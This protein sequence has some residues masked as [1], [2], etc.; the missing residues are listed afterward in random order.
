MKRPN[1][2]LINA[3]VLLTI[4]V[5]LAFSGI[6]KNAK[7]AFSLPSGSAGLSA[8]LLSTELGV[9]EVHG[10]LDSIG[11]DSY[12]VG[13]FTFRF[14][15]L[16]MVTGDLAV[17]DSVHIKALLLPDA[18][19]YALSIEE[20]ATPV[21]TSEFETYGLVDSME[22]DVWVISSGIVTLTG[23]TVIDAG[24]EVGDLVQVHGVIS[25]GLLVAG[26]ITLVDGDPV[27]SGT[28]VE[29]FGTIESITGSV[30][31][32][33]G[34]TVNTDAL[35]LIDPGLMVGDLVKVGAILNADGTYLA[36]AIQLAIMPAPED[37]TFTGAVESISDS[38]WLVGGMTF[39]VDAET[40]ITGDPLVGDMVLVTYVEQSDGSFLALEITKVEE[41]DDD[42][43]NGSRVFDFIGALESISDTEWVVGGL[44]FA[45]TSKT[46]LEGEMAVGDIV[47]VHAKRFSDGS[48]VAM[49]IHPA[50]ENA[51]DFTFVGEV[52][53]M[54][55]AAWVIDG[56]TLVIDSSTKINGH[57]SVGDLVKVHAKLNEDGTYTAVKI[58]PNGPR[59]EDDEDEDDQ[60]VVE[61]NGTVESVAEGSWVVGGMTFIVD[62]STEFE[63]D[64][65]LGDFVEVEY[66][67]Q[68]DG[69]LLA[70]KI[71]A[72]N[73]DGP[74][75][76]EEVIEFNGLVE[77]VAEDLWVIGGMSF[78][79]A[80]FTEFEGDPEL[81]DLVEVEYA[82]RSNGSF[83][84]YKID[85]E[86][87][88]GSEADSGDN[89][90][91]KSKEDQDQW[92]RNGGGNRKDDSNSN[93]DRDEDRDEDR[94]DDHDEDSDDDRGEDRDGRR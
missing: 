51:D 67:L 27:G 50:R 61:F 7:A 60:D 15:S 30:Y 72:E 56:F 4:A 70:L 68:S 83:Q 66:V 63:G 79:V 41:G 23:A 32:I 59:D 69:S 65:Q 39:L 12:V 34:K 82:V 9:I 93:R 92:T 5:G 20:L 49:K 19:S 13:G 44:S 76:D 26:T 46:E 21:T 89:R 54:G 88:D 25:A 62:S 29:F 87:D 52:E 74:T 57:I 17:G 64:P 1:S 73:D 45:I 90:D 6:P 18:T 81:G 8:D 42:E 78:V 53:S 16:T 48:L 86:D 37:L 31:V 22:T 77:S 75:G 14:D 35:T 33:T 10:V 40:V 47:K 91:Q 3:V 36:S 58:H 94:D 28:E 11:V 43:E 80:P 2:V 55:D 85:A 84:A 24:I 38:Q 71:D